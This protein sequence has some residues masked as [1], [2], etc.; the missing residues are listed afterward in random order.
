MYTRHPR[1]RTAARL[2]RLAAV[3]RPAGTAASAI[4]KTALRAG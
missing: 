1:P 3:A 2:L 4:G